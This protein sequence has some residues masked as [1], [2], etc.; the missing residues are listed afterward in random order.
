MV[1]TMSTFGYSE[2]VRLTFRN[3]S[4]LRLHKGQ[5][6]V[7]LSRRQGAALWVTAQPDACV[8]NDGGA[9]LV[10]DAAAGEAA[11]CICASRGWEQSWG[12]VFP[13]HKV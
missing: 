1:K 7:T 8:Q 4:E 6:E 11:I 10:D 9:V 3:S 5:V 12:H 2:D 13:V